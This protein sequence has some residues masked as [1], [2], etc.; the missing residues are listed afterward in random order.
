MEQLTD[1]PLGLFAV[2]LKLCYSWVASSQ[3]S[4]ESIKFTITECAAGWARWGAKAINEQCRGTQ[5]RFCGRSSR[6][7]CWSSYVSWQLHSFCSKTKYDN[8]ILSQPVLKLICHTAVHLPFLS[9]QQEGRLTY[10]WLY[11]L[12]NLATLFTWGKLG[13]AN[14]WKSYRV[15]L[16]GWI[17][18]LNEGRRWGTDKV[19]RQLTNGSYLLE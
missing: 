13:Y 4:H 1:Y 5:G 6:V 3:L 2:E 14:N 12:A 16:R 7:S 19:H 18:I 9:C 10:P 11:S 8:N 17:I 15:P